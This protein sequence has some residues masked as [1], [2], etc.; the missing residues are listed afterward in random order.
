MKLRQLSIVEAFDLVVVEFELWGYTSQISFL[1]AIHEQVIWY[2]SS[3]IG[4]LSLFIKWWEEHGASK[5]LGVEQSDSTIEITTIHKAKGLEKRVVIIPFCSWD[6]EPKASGGSGTL[7]W[8]NEPS[9]GDFPLRAKSMIAQSYMAS[10]YYR[11]RVYSHID[12]INLLYVALTR[13]V[14]ALYIFTKS[15]DSRVGGMLLEALPATLSNLGGVSSQRGENSYHL[16]ADKMLATQS[17]KGVSSHVVKIDNYPTRESELTLSLPSQRYREDS[18]GGYSPRDIGILMHR[19]FEGA[20]SSDDIVEGVEHMVKTAQISGAEG[21][22]IT[23]IYRGA[24]ENPIVREWFEPSWDRVLC[25]QSIIIPASSQIRRPDRVMIKGDRAV[26]VDYKFGALNG[27]RYRRQVAQYM[28][29][30]TQMGYKRVEGWIWQIKNG[31][32][33]AV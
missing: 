32:I 31:L 27:E 16:F 19:L 8:A 14:D 20:I 3:K 29:L 12:A 33:E 11:E 6:V 1:Q 28:E 10:E 24:M 13:A 4:D 9:V 17:V 23:H 15:K 26:V 25:E 21:E 5:S 2:A 18:E 30:L 7:I 22:I